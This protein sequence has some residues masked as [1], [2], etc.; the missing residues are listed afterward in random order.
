VGGVGTQHPE[1][2]TVRGRKSAGGVIELLSI[3]ALDTLDGVS[4]LRGHVSK[5]VREG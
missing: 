4:K 3:I 1:L 2:D 5:E